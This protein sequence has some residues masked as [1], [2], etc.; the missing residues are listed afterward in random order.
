VNI[1]KTVANAA[2][3]RNDNRVQNTLSVIL[4]QLLVD[5][6]HSQEI[7]ILESLLDFAD[8]LEDE[9]L[10]AEINDLGLALFNARFRLADVAAWKGF[11]LQ[12]VTDNARSTSLFRSSP[13]ALNLPVV[14]QQEVVDLR[15]RLDNEVAI[16]GRQITPDQWLRRTLLQRLTERERKAIQSVVERMMDRQQSFLTRV[17]DADSGSL[18]LNV[19]RAGSQL[20]HRLLIH[21]HH[22]LAILLLP[23]ALSRLPEVLVL[24]DDTGSGEAR[25]LLLSQL[26]V[27]TL[28]SITDRDIELVKMLVPPLI[29]VIS[30]GVVRVN[31]QLISGGWP[32]H[33]AES[34]LVVGG[35]AF[36]AR[37][38]TGDNLF[39]DAITQAAASVNFPLEEF[40]HV[41]LPQF[42]ER[43]RISIDFESHLVMEYYQ[44]C[45]VPFITLIEQLPK[46][47]YERDDKDG[48]SPFHPDH[49]SQFIWRA[50]MYFQPVDCVKKFLELISGLTVNEEDTEDE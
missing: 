6:W 44:E 36:F 39:I 49:P 25:I 23:T 43:T 19:L 34:L 7:A 35:L 21:G 32:T 16:S 47:P 5:A 4:S 12:R 10:P 31:G 1:F 17:L 28:R 15:R 27:M 13:Y 41:M 30:Q 2:R 37:E 22:D 38:F 3:D 42:S 11:E 33:E 45:F 14:I 40:G 9:M 29:H 24:A 46:V 20:C 8:E 18:G 48:F 26:R 50:S